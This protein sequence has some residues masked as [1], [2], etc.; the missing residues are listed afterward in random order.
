MS[1]PSALASWIPALCLCTAGCQAGGARTTWQQDREDGVPAASPLVRNPAPSHPR[2]AWTPGATEADPADVAHELEMSLLRFTARRR[3]LS[4]E[5]ATQG[6]GAWPVPLVQAWAGV[7]TTL[8]RGFRATSEPMPTRVLIQARVTL[9]AERDLCIRRHGPPPEV[10]NQ[11]VLAVWWTVAQQIRAHRGVARSA[12]TPDAGRAGFLW[13]V[14]PI[15]VTSSFGFRRDPI[16]GEE[17]VRF[18]AGLDLGGRRGD[19]VVASGA[20]RVTAAGW[21]GGHGRS[22]TIQHPQGYSTRYAHLSRILVTQ[23]AM[24]EAGQALGLMGSTGR[25]TGPHLHFELRQGSV[26]ID[27]MELL[28]GEPS[29]YA[30]N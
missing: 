13:P 10:I 27:P 22:V 21:E 8:E 25:S 23:G 29:P 7:L 28:R 1:K 18:H 26:P 20:G 11:R 17:Q 9:E 4:A 19:V 12:I 16:L 3:A 24:I 2:P 14:S 6:G 15:I 5:A 30:A